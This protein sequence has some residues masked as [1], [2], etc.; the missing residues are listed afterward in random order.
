MDHVGVLEG[1]R[2][3]LIDGVSLLDKKTLKLD[4]LPKIWFLVVI[5]VEMDVQEDITQ[6]YGIISRIL[7]LLL[8]IIM[9]I[10]ITVNLIL[11]PLVLMELMEIK[12]LELNTELLNAD[13]IVIQ[14]INLKVILKIYILL[15]LLD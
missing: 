4:C 2:P 12:W 5:S 3:L 15:N 11:F 1:L 10:K 9:V 14:L 7:E 8:E 13:M 6:W